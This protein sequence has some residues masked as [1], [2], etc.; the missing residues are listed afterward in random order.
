MLNID[1]WLMSEFIDEALAGQHALA[2][3]RHQCLADEAGPACRENAHPVSFLRELLEPRTA[4]A[5]H[6]KMGPRFEFIG[7]PRLRCAA[8]VQ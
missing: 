2:D 6:G 4:V 8:P 1:H 5:T 3:A 7:A